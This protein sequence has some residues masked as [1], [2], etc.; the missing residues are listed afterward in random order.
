MKTVISTGFSTCPND[1]FIFDALVNKKIEMDDPVFDPV[2]ED[3]ETLNRMALSG[4][5][6]LT[7]ISYHAYFHV[8]DRYRLLTTGSALGNHCGPLLV[9]YHDFQHGDVEKLSIAIPGKLTTAAFLLRFAFP[10]ALQLKEMPFDEIEDAVLNREV[11]AGVI[12][13][14]NRFTYQSKGLKKI[15]DLGQIWEDRTGNPIPLGGIAILRS[16]D[17]DLTVKV[18]RALAASVAH[19]SRWPE[20]ALPFIKK[21]AA[22]LNT[23]IIMAHIGLYVGKYTLNLGDVGRQAIL[24]MAGQVRKLYPDLR[25]TDPLFVDD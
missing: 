20:K 17:N 10:E 6:S 21:H 9:S 18:N 3:V 1:T 7:K 23:D 8:S 5:L 12:I 19:A 14:E 25:I 2:I 4:T 16:I 15:C 24:A 22:S 13:H 11:E